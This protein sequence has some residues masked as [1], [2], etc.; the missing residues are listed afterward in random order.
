MIGNFLLA[1]GF[2]LT[3]WTPSSDLDPV[4]GPI[5]PGALVPSDPVFSALLT[6]GSQV[7]G[8]IRRLGEVDG[9]MLVNENGEE[10]SIPV[11]RLVKLVRE[12]VPPQAP[13]EGGDLVLFPDG[14]R[15]ARCKIGQSGEFTIGVHSTAFDQLAIPLDAL[16]GLVFDTN[17]ESAATDALISRVRSEPREAELL[18]LVNGDKLP[19]LFS[20]LD[21]KKLTFQP[22]TG[23]VD[24]PRTGVLALGFPQGQ[25]VYRRP[26]GP[27]FELKLADGS[28]L[29][30]NQVK[31]ERGQ[32]LATTRFKVP[33][34]FPIG[35]LAQLHVMNSSVLYL[36]DREASGTIYEPYIGPTRPY[37]R[38]A[39][40]SG[41]VLR[42]GGRAYERGLGTQ[43]RTL[44]VY[45][46]EPGS[47]RFQALIGVDDRA[48]PLGNVIFKVQGDKKTLFESAPM[49]S[50]E[51]PRAVDVDLTG[52]GFLIL[53]T[54]FGDRG[55][56][57]DH[58]DWVEARIIR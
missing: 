15:L 36:S 33:I 42:L 51:P 29:G 24:L 40:V 23:K 21:E 6:D 57:Q 5:P 12:G 27:Y 19:G 52:A 34:R 20:G 13:T 53:I 30:V 2:G 41:E 45:K 11:N 26:E 32:G 28:R 49:V 37:R 1:L 56:V 39:T 55:D 48:G 46:L 7:S 47:K 10:R 38:N 9:V 4:D 14:D 8:Q 3:I 22:E 50:G 44:L 54:E 18:W 35:D 31:I 16:L 58:A 43:S 17:S 25:V